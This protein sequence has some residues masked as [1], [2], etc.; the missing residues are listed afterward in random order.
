M[1]LALHFKEV[2]VPDDVDVESCQF[3]EPSRVR[4][5]SG[6]SRFAQGAGKCTFAEPGNSTIDASTS[7][8]VVSETA[9]IG[10][11]TK[12]TGINAEAWCGGKVCTLV[13]R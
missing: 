8:R 10:I 13:D 9:R 2:V 4:H 6:T 7:C 1:S 3:K 11:G 5:L 12:R